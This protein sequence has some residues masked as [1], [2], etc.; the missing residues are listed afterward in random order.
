M[1]LRITIA[2]HEALV[3]IA[4]VNGT[5]ISDEIRA[6]IDERIEERRRDPEFKE[7]LREF[8]KQRNRLLA[9]LELR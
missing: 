4:K 9:R 1:T 6:A 8:V 2:D 3:D 7:R 5:T